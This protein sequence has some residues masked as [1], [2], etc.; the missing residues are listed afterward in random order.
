MLDLATGTTK[1]STIRVKLT[2]STS[3]S[4]LVDIAQAIHDVSGVSASVTAEGKLRISADTD[5]LR[6]SFQDDSSGIL[7][8]TGINTFFVGNSA[9]TIG[10]NP[11]IAN[12]PR[13]FAASST[14][15]GAGQA[16]H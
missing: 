12:N 9:S 11:V 4:S 10:L 2:G 7:A 8:A 15:V 13:L 1:T 14:G 6:F 16:M 3:D 5:S